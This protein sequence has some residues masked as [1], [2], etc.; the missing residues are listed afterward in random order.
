MPTYRVPGYGN[1]VAYAVSD[2]LSLLGIV[3]RVSEPAGEIRIDTPAIT[4]RLRREILPTRNNRTASFA[5]YQNIAS[6]AQ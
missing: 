3:G 5:N 4:V 6:L 2:E 1:S